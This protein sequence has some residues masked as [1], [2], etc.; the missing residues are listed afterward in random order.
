MTFFAKRKW[1]SFQCTRTRINTPVKHVPRNSNGVFF[2][3]QYIII[4][5]IERA[6]SI[7]PIVKRIWLFTFRTF[8][9]VLIEACVRKNTVRRWR[10]RCGKRASRSRKKGKY[11]VFRLISVNRHLRKDVMEV[12]GGI[13]AASNCHNILCLVSFFVFLARSSRSVVNHL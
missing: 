7:Y 3:K 8:R 10:K 9:L 4:L 11:F 2:G 5:T 13:L 1:E 6:S 12:A